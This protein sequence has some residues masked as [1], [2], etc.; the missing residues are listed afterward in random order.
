[1][2]RPRGQFAMHRLLDRAT[3]L[4]ELRQAIPCAAPPTCEAALET[5]ALAATPL[6]VHGQTTERTVNAAERLARALGVTVRL[7]APFG[8]KNL[9]GG[10]GPRP[11]K[12]AP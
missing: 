7:L 3:Q 12:R 1:M 6:F 5:V 11:T 2:E 10:G 8:G 9:R 4:T